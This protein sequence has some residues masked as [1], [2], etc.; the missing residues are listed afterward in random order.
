MTDNSGPGQEPERKRSLLLSPVGIGTMALLGTGVFAGTNGFG[1]G[2]RP[3]A[4]QQIVTS[5]AQCQA[6]MGGP[7]CA[8]AFGAGAEAVGL[9]RTGNG[10]WS[11]QPLR[12]L[13]GGTYQTLSGSAFTLNTCSS[14]SSSS[15]SSSSSFYYGG[16]SSGTS[17]STAG[18]SSTSRGGFGTTA[19]SFSSRGS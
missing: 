16:G 12:A 6:L 1:L 18:Q 2:S 9:T 4:T 15:R 17:G 19:S 3:C 7:G 5:L 14:S 8:T 11:H 10:G 13:S